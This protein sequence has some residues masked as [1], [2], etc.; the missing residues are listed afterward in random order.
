MDHARNAF[1]RSR[2]GIVSL[3]AGLACAL[4]PAAQAQALEPQNV[5]A[6]KLVP[7]ARWNVGVRRPSTTTLEFAGKNSAGTNGW[8][9]VGGLARRVGAKK[10][11]TLPAAFTTTFGAAYVGTSIP[12]YVYAAWSD[13]VGLNLCVSDVANLSA[14]QSIVSGN[15]G[16]LHCAQSYLAAD[17]VRMLGSITA[18]ATA[19][20]VSD[21]FVE[22]GA[23][24]GFMFV[25]SASSASTGTSLS[26]PVP[27][28]TSAYSCVASVKS[29]GTG[30]N[31]VKTVAAG[32]AAITAVVDTAQTTGTTVLNYA[33]FAN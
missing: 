28:L 7:S 23:Q 18:N 33:C 12:M 11:L 16:Y 22:S 30:P 14:V 9:E 27:G 4:A 8:L 17:P 10:T 32:A 20:T 25:G 31:Y 6:V 26:F 1:S 21:S 24:R 15:S 2:L 3:L 19:N 13:S 5:D 29:L